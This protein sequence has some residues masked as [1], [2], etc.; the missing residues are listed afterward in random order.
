MPMPSKLNRQSRSSTVVS[1]ARSS[2][3][4]GASEYFQ[5][6]LPRGWQHYFIARRAGR[7]FGIP[8]QCPYENCGV[9][10]PEHLKYYSQRWKWITTHLLTKHHTGL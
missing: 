2:Q 6:M 5:S 1:I 8:C 3:P 7:Y 4:P 10:P 9:K